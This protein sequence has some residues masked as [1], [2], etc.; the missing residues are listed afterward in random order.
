M[1]SGLSSGFGARQSLSLNFDLVKVLDAD[2][3]AAADGRIQL[4]ARR[5]GRR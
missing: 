1:Q 3:E 5:L 2:R 4:F